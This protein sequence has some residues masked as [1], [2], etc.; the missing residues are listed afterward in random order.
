MDLIDKQELRHLKGRLFDLSI[1]VNALCDIHATDELITI[2]DEIQWLKQKINLKLYD[3][4]K[5]RYELEDT[6]KD[7]KDFEISVE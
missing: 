4:E 3:I 6:K 2:K 1:K 5:I 7:L